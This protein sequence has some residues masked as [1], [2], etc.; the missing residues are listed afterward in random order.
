MICTDFCTRSQRG[1][2]MIELMA[3]VTII[4]ILAVIAIPN[5]SAY[6]QRSRITEATSRLADFRVKMEQYYQDNRHY[7]NANCAD[8]NAPGWAA[9][10]ATKYFSYAC[11]VSG[12]TANGG[13]QQYT[14]T[15]TGL[16]GRATGHIF[17]I[18]NFPTDPTQRTTQF[19][20]SAVNK[21]CWLVKGTEC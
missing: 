15:A 7:G 17:T 1:F 2:S 13:R 11:A 4:G 3:V 14:V 19:K 21:N 12:V 6:I 10:T 5:Y 16:T 9:F 8:V 18:A 20:G